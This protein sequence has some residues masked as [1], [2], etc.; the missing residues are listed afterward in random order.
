M[1]QHKVVLLFKAWNDF[2]EKYLKKGFL[3]L[4]QRLPSCHGRTLSLKGKL[5]YMEHFVIF[6][7]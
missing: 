5:V 4:H 6:K 3:Q 2:S 1:F 7:C